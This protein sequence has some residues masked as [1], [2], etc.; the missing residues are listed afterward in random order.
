MMVMLIS[1]APAAERKHILSIA[2]HQAALRTDDRWNWIECGTVD[3]LN[4][5]AEE[6]RRIDI[7]CIDLT[8]EGSV[9]TV[10]VLRRDNPES[11]IILIADNRISPVVYMR[12]QIR[13]E[14]LML[15]PLDD[16]C[17]T[18]TVDEAIREY[19]NRNEP[20]SGKIFVA[21]SRGEKS[22]VEFGR[23]NFFESRDKKVYLCTDAEE[24]GFYE[25]LEQL[26]DKLRGEFLRVHRSFL[27][28]RRKIAKVVLSKN[29][30]YLQNGEELP[31][32]RSYKNAM[33]EY[34]EEA[35][36]NESDFIV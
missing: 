15:K 4:I 26:E 25:T 12:P 36:N 11:Y 32:S 33:K 23:I 13:A 6:N 31:L 18:G 22:I 21:E 34:L 3:D 7:L 28:N 20:D 9:D 35:E 19:L 16:V 10:R 8:I 1:D 14:S 17:V 5:A 29:R 2:R 24:F 30:V 27:V